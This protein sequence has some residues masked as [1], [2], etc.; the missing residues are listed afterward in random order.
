MIMCCSDSAPFC[1]NTWILDI[2]CVWCYFSSVETVDIQ[3][4]SCTLVQNMLISVIWYS[5]FLSWDSPTVISLKSGL[6]E[7]KLFL[8][9]VVTYRYD[10]SDKCILLIHVSVADCEKCFVQFPTY[11]HSLK[12]FPVCSCIKN[13]LSVSYLSSLVFRI[14]FS[15]F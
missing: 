5:T 3:G 6:K 11:F 2:V 13:R 4:F 12:H 8:L 7:S 10:I 9:I 15:V 14:N 1:F